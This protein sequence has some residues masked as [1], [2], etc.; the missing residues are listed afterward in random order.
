ML[1]RSNEVRDIRDMAVANKTLLDARILADSEH[2]RNVE[3]GLASMRTETD[4][5]HA[6]NG[7]RFAILEAKIDRS[8]DE[9]HGRVTDMGNELSGKIHDT[10]WSGVRWLSIIIGAIMLIAVAMIGQ[11]LTNGAPWQ[12]PQGKVGITRG[13]K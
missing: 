3:Q 8:N 4:R 1:A 7:G 2:H 9:L 6:E 5:R 11:L 12:Q 13:A 10:A